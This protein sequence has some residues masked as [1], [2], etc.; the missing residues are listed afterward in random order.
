MSKLRSKWASPQDLAVVQHCSVEGHPLW[1]RALQPRPS[2][3]MR[4]AAKD[5]T[6]KWVIEPPGGMLE[7]TA[8]SDV[9]FL[10]GQIPELARGGWSFA[11]LN[12]EATLVASAY[13]VPP[14]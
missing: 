12:G 13:G 14:S 8:Y 6:F 9:S 2:K 1:E 7:G 10:D 5:A 3:P 4:A 11:I